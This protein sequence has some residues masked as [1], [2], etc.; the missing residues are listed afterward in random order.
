MSLSV[1]AIQQ[2]LASQTGITSLVPQANITLDVPM[3][4]A[5]LPYIILTQI[6][7]VSQYST[8]SPRISRLHLQLAVY[9]ATL[10]S[11]DAV[12]S[13]VQAAL[14]VN[15][16]VTMNTWGLLLVSGPLPRG[17]VQGAYSVILEYLISQNLT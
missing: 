2:Y 1:L 12:T 17:Q 11:A 16:A 9:G 6:S 3:D 8:S 4:G 5:A 13:A 14:P 10:A 7:D 15:T